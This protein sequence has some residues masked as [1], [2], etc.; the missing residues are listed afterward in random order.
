MERA[1]IL[2]YLE[3]IYS[4]D[5]DSIFIQRL[6]ICQKERYN[7]E[8]NLDAQMRLHNFISCIHIASSEW[9][10]VMI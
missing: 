3:A 2:S 4:V 6:K 1:A 9:V 10:N 5:L 8:T 7:S